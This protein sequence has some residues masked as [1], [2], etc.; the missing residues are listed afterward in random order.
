MLSDNSKKKFVKH[1]AY[2]NNIKLS[3]FYL[4]VIIFVAIISLFDNF[5]KIFSLSCL[6]AFCITLIHSSK[7]KK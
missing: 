3:N 1:M 5:F 2:I 7:G 6:I 4:Y